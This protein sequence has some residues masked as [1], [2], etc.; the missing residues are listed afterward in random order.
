[1]LVDFGADISI[2]PRWTGR[3]LGLRVDE[4]DYIKEDEGT[5]TQRGANQNFAPIEINQI[6]FGKVCLQICEKE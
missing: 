3:V 6:L 4:N 2:I 1:M 5:K